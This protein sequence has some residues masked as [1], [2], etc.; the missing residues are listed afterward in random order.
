M[1]ILIIPPPTNPSSNC[2][3]STPPVEVTEQ[4]ESCTPGTEKLPGVN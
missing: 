2:K 3:G 1:D 4:L